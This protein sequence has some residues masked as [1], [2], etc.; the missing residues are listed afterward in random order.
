M[1]AGTTNVTQELQAVLLVRARMRA[2]CEAE[3]LQHFL[4]VSRTMP[5]DQGRRYLAWV[6]GQSSMHGHGMEKR[7]QMNMDDMGGQMG[8]EHQM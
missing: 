5:P 4:E 7:H 6:Q 8:G 1:L 3:M 2:D